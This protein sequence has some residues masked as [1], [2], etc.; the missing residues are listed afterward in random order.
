MSSGGYAILERVHHVL[1]ILGF[2]SGFPIYIVK[3][4]ALEAFSR[5]NE[6]TC[7]FIDLIFLESK[8]LEVTSVFLGEGLPRLIILIPDKI[9]YIR[10]IELI[11]GMAVSLFPCISDIALKQA[12]KAFFEVFALFLLKLRHHVMR[13]PDQ[14]ILTGSFLLPELHCHRN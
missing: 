13:Q 11:L 9:A 3:L 8:S 12:F 2:L 10:L 1:V 6:L 14:G 4:F 7:I 5:L